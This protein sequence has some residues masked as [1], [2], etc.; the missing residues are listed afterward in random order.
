MLTFL[1][2][3]PVIL[4]AVM[5]INGID[6]LISASIGLFVAAFI[7]KCTEKMKF[8]DIMNEAVEGAKDATLLAFILM[9]AYALAEI[10][11]STGVGAAAISIFIHA[12]VTGKTVAVVA[13]LTTCALS[14]S[15]G[16]SWG[17]FAA[18]IPI[19]IWLC[20]VVGGNPAM[21]FAAAVGGSAFGDNIGLISD[22]TI[23][24]SGLQGVKVV[25]RIRAQGPWSV[26][27]VILSA[28]CFYAFSVAM[29]L[30]NTVG[31]PAQIL[32][33]MSKET[34][35]ILQEERPTV[36]TLLAQVKD[37]VPIYMIIPVIIVI[38]MAVMRM[39]TISCLSTGIACA[40]LFGY[41]AGTVTSFKDVVDLVQSGFE[42]AGSWAVIMLFWAMG[43]GAVMRRM[44]AFGPIAALFVR[45]SRRVRHLVVCNGVLCLI[46]NATLNEEMS[47]MA[48]VGPVI[49]DIID[50]NVEGSE[51]GKYKLRNRNALFSDAVGVHSAA[52]IP[53]HTGVA[54]YMG[55]AAAVYPLYHFT[56]GDLYYNFMG[57]ICVISIYVLT[58]TG[59]DR[60]IPLFGLPSEPD[61][62]LKKAEA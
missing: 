41:V 20:N 50:K 22:T 30:P 1:K 16:T 17:T 58:F 34:V 53:W 61:V 7:C 48:T 8:G 21:T 37:G 56:I 42:S 47:Q 39:D 2:L 13:F 57:I 59:W 3:S 51:E 6:I 62:K 40:I 26:I 23:L 27:C 29:D 52:L 60:F 4:L 35:A 12:G 5:V 9:L 44:D 18:C 25:D 33:S 55:L 31:D 36:L 28:I 24:S 15:T 19:F 43:F 49:K 11:M 10:F 38:T 54:Y 45:V 46:I 32:A 14:V